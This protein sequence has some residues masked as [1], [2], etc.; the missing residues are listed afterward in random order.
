MMLRTSGSSQ[1]TLTRR[2]ERRARWPRSIRRIRASAAPDTPW[3]HTAPWEWFVV[4]A[5]KGHRLV[6][7]ALLR[8]FFE[9]DADFHDLAVHANHQREGCGTALCEEAIAWMTELECS[10]VSALPTSVES[11]RVFSR[12]GFRPGPVSGALVLPL[13]AD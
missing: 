1:V 4:R 12:C 6:G 10:G 11:Y 7:Y 13:R 2:T 8:V 5:H 3:P 9:G